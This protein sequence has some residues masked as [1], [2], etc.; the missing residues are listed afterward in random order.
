MRKIADSVENSTNGKPL[1]GAIVTMNTGTVDLYF[2]VTLYATND[3][4]GPSMSSVTTDA[5]G[6]YEF[7]VPDGSYI[8]KVQYGDI[9]KLIPDD[10]NY[11]LSEM[12][13]LAVGAAT[14]DLAN[15][16]DAVRLALSPALTISGDG[17]FYPE[18]T[19][20]LVS[21]TMDGEG[22]GFIQS[23]A[24][25]NIAESMSLDGLTSGA[26]INGLYI[27]K[28]TASG[29][30]PGARNALH[31]V[32]GHAASTGSP[33]GV[34]FHT[35]IFGTTYVTAND[36]GSPGDTRG[37][38]YGFGGIVTLKDGVEDV[39]GVIGAEFDVAVEDGA[40]VDEKMILQ[41]VTV[42]SDAVKGDVVDAG[43]VICG[44]SSVDETTGWLDYGIVF[45]KPGSKNVARGTLIGGYATSSNGLDAISGVDFSGFTFSDSAF[46]SSGFSVSG[47]GALASK[48][49]TISAANCEQRFRDTI[50]AVT[51][52][53]LVRL[54]AL[55]GSWAF[56]INTAAGGDFGT[57]TTAYTIGPNGGV[58]FGRPPVTPV[59]SAGTLP[60]ASPA[61]QRTFVNDASAT[62]FAST[63]AG[64]GANFVPVYSDGTNWKIG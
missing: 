49:H 31:A 61:G 45:G 18:N 47:T 58:T 60:S 50:T 32:L 56:Q 27:N 54:T 19:P 48:S 63:V 1:E 25:I 57:V 42:N 46:K 3:V 5:D 35:A 7:Y 36:G 26:T 38:F 10:E 20:L 59:Y 37:D 2:P 14:S 51:S 21:G 44:D 9:Y 55:S 24:T 53:G 13:G 4:S 17:G 64:G 34:G 12:K 23:A 40:S 52:G 15:V 41:L 11:D 62:T 6:Y 43:I 30:G 29:A 16:S 28:A 8:R 22:S 39:H 33:F